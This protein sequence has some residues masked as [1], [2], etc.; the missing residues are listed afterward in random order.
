MNPSGSPRTMKI[1]SLG[2]WVLGLGSIFKGI[3][4]VRLHATNDE[5]RES[6]VLGLGSIS[7]GGLHVYSGGWIGR[8]RCD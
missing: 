2:S 4:H 5:N 7:V 3:A 6:W 1:E 8:L